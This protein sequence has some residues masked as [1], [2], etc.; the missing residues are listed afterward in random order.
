MF[1]VAYS[2]G[3]LA[4]CS[5]KEPFVTHQWLV[6]IILRAALF[7]V[8][9]SRNAATGLALPIRSAVGRIHIHVVYRAHSD[10]DTR[11]DMAVG[12]DLLVHGFIDVFGNAIARYS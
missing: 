10:R 6:I 3:E 2:A 11:L 4:Q 12:G 8:A 5:T 9:G 7:L 1:F